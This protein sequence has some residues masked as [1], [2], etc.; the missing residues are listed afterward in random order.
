MCGG[1]TFLILSQTCPLNS[2]PFLPS[3]DL[4]DLNFRRLLLGVRKSCLV[5]WSSTVRHSG[6]GIWQ[7]CGVCKEKAKASV[8]AAVLWLQC[9]FTP[10]DSATFMWHLICQRTGGA[11]VVARPGCHCTLN[12]SPSACQVS[13]GHGGGDR[14]GGC[15]K[16]SDQLC[17]LLRYRFGS[18]CQHNTRICTALLQLSCSNHSVAGPA[19]SG[20]HFVA[21][22]TTVSE[23]QRCP[24]AQKDWGPLIPQTHPGTFA[25]LFKRSTSSADC[26]ARC[27]TLSGRASSPTPSPLRRRLSSIQRLQGVPGSYLQGLHGEAVPGTSA[28]P[29]LQPEVLARPV[30]ETSSAPFG[31]QPT[32]E[33]RGSSSLPPAHLTQQEIQLASS[34]APPPLSTPLMQQR[35]RMLHRALGRLW[36]EDRAPVGHARGATFNP[37]HLC[38]R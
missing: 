35:L 13:S 10:P 26:S 2:Q 21:M 37:W 36:Q 28:H 15:S 14:K 23:F 19:S 33:R 38:W 27:E 24:Q 25:V 32:K 5:L 11:S 30:A 3:C 4:L 20:S 1:G 34:P 9:S 18:S 29:L 16:A 31:A 7:A 17:R 6:L 12:T 8:A 22:A